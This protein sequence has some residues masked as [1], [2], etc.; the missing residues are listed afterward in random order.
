MKEGQ[1]IVKSNLVYSYYSIFITSTME[2]VEIADVL[3]EFL[4]CAIHSIL[5]TRK[6][7]PSEIFEPRMKY[8]LTVQQ[9]RHPDINLY[10]KQVL[11]EA[12]PLLSLGA[13]ERLLLAVKDSNDTK[14][15]DI[16]SI[17]FY[18]KIFLVLGLYF[19]SIL[20]A[21]GY[22]SCIKSKTFFSS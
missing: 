21:L 17:H 22:I 16:T 18:V 7:Y 13:V 3:L 6:I 4:E 10:I 1:N 20:S 19:F 9:C 11:K 15:V 14:I 8:Q 12:K 2:N 5:Y